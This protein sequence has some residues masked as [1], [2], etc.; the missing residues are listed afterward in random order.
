MLVAYGRDISALS[1]AEVAGLVRPTK[2]ARFPDDVIFARGLEFSGIYEDGWLSPES[3]YVLG[4]SPAAGIVRLR[5]EIPQMPGTPL[6]TGRLHVR[7]GDQDYEM[8][9]APGTFDWLLPVPARAD[10]TR[11]RL[12]FTATTILPGLDARPIGGRLELIEV[13]PALP[14]HTFEFGTAGKARLP[15]SG[16]DQ[17]GW[18][19]RQAR[20]ELPAGGRRMLMLKIEFPDWSGKSSGRLNF[21]FSGAGTP[22]AQALRP[23]EY[24]TVLLPVAASPQTQ[25]LTLSAD[26]DFPLPSP[27]TRR[28]AAR[29]VVAELQPVER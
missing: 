22:H 29:L 5:G 16:I 24:T 26:D 12:R 14:T 20:I 27:D 28:R 17:D 3:E 25:T 23:G 4:P 1:V 19:E 18:L 9:A 2:L 13:L 8:P 15:A 21:S 7:L 6:G 11:L 10:T